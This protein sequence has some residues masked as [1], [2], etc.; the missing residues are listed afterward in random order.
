MLS[1]QERYE[2]VDLPFYREQIAPILP[3]QVL[4]FHTHIWRSE[5]W[6]KVPWKTDMAGGR[7]MVSLEHYGIEGLI[8]DLKSFFPDR[9]CQAVCFGMPTPAA[10][11]EKTNAYSAQAA[12]GQGLFPLLVV[13][14]DTIPPAALKEV[15]SSGTYFGYKV[16][17]NWHG[18]DY[19]QVKVE[20][21]IGPA[22]LELA[23]E[24]GL[25]VLLHVPRAGRLADPEV[26]RGLREYARAYPK[27]KFVLAHCGR[28]YH[29]DEMQAAIGAITDL[30]NVYMDTAMV[31]DPLVLQM[32][33][34]QIDSHRVLFASDL[35]IANMRGRRVYVMD[36]WVDL[37][38]EDYPESEFR[39][40][41]N[42][43]HAT[44]MIWEIVLALKRAADMAGL[45]KAQLDG[46]FYAN[47]MA[48][49]RQVMAGR[50]AGSHKEN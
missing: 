29:P 31:M 50:N 20:D 3:A 49:L 14:R 12:P 34:K 18:N 28:C 11:L 32:V 37:V 5:D 45:S 17:L 21:M 7:Y 46:V 4:D 15:I 8:G 42:N 43:M 22:E 40:L 13:G 36:H 38:F 41:S 44:F 16:Y 1:E 27:A 24:R 48:L 6:K 19:G 30:E 39:V 10:D 35:P 47:G 33:F 2:T 23:D 25:I 26:Q 9:P